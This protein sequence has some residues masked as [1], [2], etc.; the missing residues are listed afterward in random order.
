[1][2]SS[3]RS[4]S[5]GR[6]D[7]KT[8]IN[9]FCELVWAKPLNATTDRENTAA[10]RASALAN[11]RAA[12]KFGA[13]DLPRP[14]VIHIWA[15][16]AKCFGL[17]GPDNKDDFRELIELARRINSGL[18]K[19]MAANVVAGETGACG[20]LREAI[21]DRL[22]RAFGK[23]ADLYHQ[24]AAAPDPRVAINQIIFEQ[25]RNS[26]RTL[27]SALSLEYFGIPLRPE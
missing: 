14:L 20:N 15:E 27:L 22:A 19:N 1:M 5:R 25:E 17:P 21:R 9:V 11:I 16:A 18:S 24:I 8:K 23:H 6:P 10:V 26:M 12:I 4:S 13:P 7:W 2:R 3:M